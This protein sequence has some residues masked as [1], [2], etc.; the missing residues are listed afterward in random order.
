MALVQHTNVRR[1]R[2]TLVAGAVVLAALTLAL[3]EV[4]AASSSPRSP[5]PGFLLDRGRYTAFD[6][7]EAVFST[8]PYGINE[9][10]Q[11]V[12]RYDDG[13]SEQGFLRNKAGRFTNIKIRDARSAWAVNINNRGHIVGI[14]SENTPLVKDPG[15]KRHGFLLAGGKL[16]RID[17][18]GA[19][20]T[21]ASGIN[22]RGQVV[23]AYVD[24]DGKFH[25]YL[26]ER[27]R[28]TTIDVPGV[29]QTIAH[30]INDRGQIVGVCGDDP[31]DPTGATG[32]HGFLLSGGDFTTFD[33]PGSRFTQ[34]TGINHRGQIVGSTFSDPALTDVHG[35]LLAKGVE[36]DFSPIDFPGAPTTLATGINDRGQVVGAY[37]NPDTAPDGQ[38]SPMRMPMMSGGDG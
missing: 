27:G 30:D 21:G 7:P 9:R 6:A 28:F 29:P 22:D 17:V 12:G 25:G 1:P 3:A 35:F 5:V 10:G 11:I 15:G 26:W 2:C 34:P 37:E 38:Q 8:L 16:T 13:G 32:V 18:P 4:P 14:Y 36:G 33:A 24:A 20:E 23:G 31:D 19:V